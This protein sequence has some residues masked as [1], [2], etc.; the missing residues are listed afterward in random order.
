[1]P[2]QQKPKKPGRPPLPKGNAKAVMLRVRV[3]PDERLAIEK[4]AKASKQT[5]SQ[6]VRALL[7]TALRS[8]LVLVLGIYALT[9]CDTRNQPQS[10]PNG[11]IATPAPK[12]NAPKEMPT[13]EAQADFALTDLV[14]ES[15]HS[16]IFNT[17][18]D[19]RPFWIVSGRITNISSMTATS[20][21][22]KL[23][24]SEK[25]S[26]R[27]LD[28]A[29]LDIKQEIPSAATVSF[30]RDVQLMLPAQGWSWVCSVDGATVRP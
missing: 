28:T 18:G 9:G 27:D 1:M 12:T 8:G 11:T 5:A 21:R 7:S 13:D 22:I 14:L 4:A 15:N 10:Q 23:V 29:V 17:N 16:A 3:T 2:K 26:G 24:A 30:R 25:A 19:R 6:W 20:V